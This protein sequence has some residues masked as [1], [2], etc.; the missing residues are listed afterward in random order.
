M[1]SEVVIV[2][3][4]GTWDFDNVGA[5]VAAAPKNLLS[6][7]GYFMIY[8]TE[9]VYEENVDIPSNKK[10]LFLLGDGMGHTIITGRRSVGDNFTTFNSAT[11]G[12]IHHFHVYMYILFSF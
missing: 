11:V 3:K 9:G 6:T 10:Y 7:D 8:V 2:S 1:V 5:A 12:N 4:D